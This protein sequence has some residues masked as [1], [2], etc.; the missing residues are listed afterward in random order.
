[1]FLLQFCLPTL[2]RWHFDNNSIEIHPA[3]CGRSRP[4]S[5]RTGYSQQICFSPYVKAMFICL[6]VF[7]ASL[8][9]FS[10]HSSSFFPLSLFLPT[11]LRWQFDN[12][13]IE[14]HS[15]NRGR[16]RPRSAGTGYSRLICFSL[17]VKAMII[18]LSCLPPCLQ[19]PLPF[20]FLSSDP[21]SMAVRQ[22]FNRN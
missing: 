9:P 8:S 11:L 7:P 19:Y 16:S 15:A 21:P 5:T 20:I 4:R 17:Y 18:C 6:L 12:N 10:A 14:I 1:M 2:L 22:Q 13:S 3:S